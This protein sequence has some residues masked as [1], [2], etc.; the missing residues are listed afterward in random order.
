MSFSGEKMGTKNGIKL[1][2]G[3]PRNSVVR[4]DLVIDWAVKSQNKADKKAVF[5]RLLNLLNNILQGHYGL[6]LEKI[7]RIIIVIFNSRQSKL[8]TI[9]TFL[10]QYHTILLSKYLITFQLATV[11][12]VL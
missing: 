8:E 4:Y 12:S 5:F 10:L 9:S 1:P 6:I 11:K 3:L 2:P 7:I